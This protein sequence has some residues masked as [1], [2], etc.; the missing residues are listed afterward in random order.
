M[1]YLAR[2]GQDTEVYWKLPLDVSQRASYDREVIID[3]AE[4]V[5]NFG[6]QGVVNSHAVEGPDGLIIYDTGADLTD[7]AQFYRMPRTVTQAPI[8]AIVYLPIIKKPAPMGPPFSFLPS[9]SFPVSSEG[10]TADIS[11][12]MG[13]SR[14]LRPSTPRAFTK[15]E[16][17]QMEIRLYKLPT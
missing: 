1:R 9:I 3:V 7:G 13:R 17:L 11:W 15:P 10:R 12:Q 14:A 6:L 2:V 16:K 5:W 8:R 4:C